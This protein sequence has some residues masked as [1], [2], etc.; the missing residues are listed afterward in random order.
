M[1]RPFVINYRKY[2]Y[3][4]TCINMHKGDT[5]SKYTYRTVVDH[6]TENNE[7]GDNT[8]EIT[9]SEPMLENIAL[10]NYVIESLEKLA[11]RQREWANK[12]WDQEQWAKDVEDIMSRNEPTKKDL[13]NQKKIVESIEACWKQ[14]RGNK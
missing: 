11:V 1:T 10:P 12:I 9:I 6:V 4:I 5:M 8:K 3:C 14:M 7:V 13:F 2:K